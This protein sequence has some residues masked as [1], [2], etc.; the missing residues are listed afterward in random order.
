MEFAFAVDF[1]AIAVTAS[2]AALLA[3]D[4]LSRATWVIGAALRG[5][6]RLYQDWS[7][8]QNRGRNCAR[9]RDRRTD[10]C[11]C[12][13]GVSEEPAVSFIGL[14]SFPGNWVGEAVTAGATS[15]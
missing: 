13:S 5:Q 1:C 10:L 15:S 12:L 7:N 3:E 6:V 14:L 9:I 8:G 11:S 4:M 2:V